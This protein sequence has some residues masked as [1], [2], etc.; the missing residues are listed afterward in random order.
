MW[1]RYKEF[2]YHSLFGGQ[3]GPSYLGDR[4][5]T[6]REDSC[7]NQGRM[8]LGD[9]VQLVVSDLLWPTG[10]NDLSHTLALCHYLPTKAWCGAQLTGLGSIDEKVEELRSRSRGDS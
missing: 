5:G 7:I 6:R 10:K 2:L 3:S 8:G 9:S 4:A 1:W